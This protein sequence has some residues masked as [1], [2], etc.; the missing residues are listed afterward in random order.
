MA[1]VTSSPTGVPGQTIDDPELRALI[2]RLS[3]LSASGEP[4][5]TASP[6]TD[7]I[8]GQPQWLDQPRITDETVEALVTELAGYPKWRFQEQVRLLLGFK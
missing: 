6:G 8:G 5:L 7:E 4:D 2:S 3:R 1:P